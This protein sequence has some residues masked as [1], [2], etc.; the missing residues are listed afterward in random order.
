MNTEGY[1]SLISQEF[2]DLYTTKKL[3]NGQ[4]DGIVYVLTAPI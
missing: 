2:A 4:Q 1:I 3:P